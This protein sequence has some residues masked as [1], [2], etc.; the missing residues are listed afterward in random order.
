MAKIKCSCSA[1][2]SS[3]W[4][5]CYNPAGRRHEHVRLAAVK[6]LRYGQPFASQGGMAWAII[7]PLTLSLTLS[8]S[9]SQL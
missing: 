5:K 9:L 8:L 7:G 2:G 1:R 4:Y 3:I 6:N